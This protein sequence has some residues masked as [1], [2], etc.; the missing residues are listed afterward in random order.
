MK[1]G[2]IALGEA[3]ID[4]IPTD[5]TNQVYYKSPG[6][7][8]ANVAVGVARLGAKST[9]IGKV[10]NDSLGRFISE[11]LSSNNVNTNQ[12]TYTSNLKTGITIV[13]NDETGERDF[14]FFIDPSA[15]RSL[16]MSDIDEKNFMEHKILHIGSISLITNPASEAT[17]YAIKLAKKNNMIVSYDPNLRLELWETEEKARQTIMSVLNE[18]DFLKVSEDELKFLTSENDIDT[19][20][21][22]LSQY[23]IPLIIVSLG[24]N[25]CVV[26]YENGRQHVPSIEVNTVDTT[27]AGDAFVAGML[28]CLNEYEG[29]IDQLTIEGIAEMARFSS[30]V[31]ALTT[32]KKGAMDA[33]PSITE[34]NEIL[35]K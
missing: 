19:G 31:G 14:E 35:N 10:G 11:T 6:G 28:Y 25:G 26:Y 24:N 5:S 29:K 12:L 23:K 22:K 21:K 1:S 15:D 18:V 7:A 2:I 4:F 8:P 17:K 33:I 9:F 34:V 20:V 30:I 32:T 3:L 16:E 27:G 13:T